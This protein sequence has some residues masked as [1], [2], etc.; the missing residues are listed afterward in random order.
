MI[1]R[2]ILSLLISF[3]YKKKKNKQIIHFF[4]HK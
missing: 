1:T 2:V 3:N 4:D